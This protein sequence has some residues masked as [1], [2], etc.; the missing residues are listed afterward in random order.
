MAKQMLQQYA[1][2]VGVPGI[3]PH[4]LRNYAE[5]RTMPNVA[6]GGWRA[7]KVAKRAQQTMDGRQGYKTV[8]VQTGRDRG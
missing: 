2:G 8:L 6:S 7:L 5:S 1:E 4:D 3:A